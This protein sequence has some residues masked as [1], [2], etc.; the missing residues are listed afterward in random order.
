MGEIDFPFQR[1]RKYP[2]GELRAFEARLFERRKQDHLFSINHC[3]SGAASW[4]QPLRE[5]LRR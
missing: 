4:E 5:H 3:A 1:A 2:L